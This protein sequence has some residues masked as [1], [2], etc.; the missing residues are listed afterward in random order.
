MAHIFKITT[1]TE[2]LIAEVNGAATASVDFTV[3]NETNKPLRGIAHIQ[4]LEQTQDAWLTLEGEPEKDFPVG[5]KQ[6]FTVKFNK[7][8]QAVEEGKTEPEEKYPYLLSVASAI[9][10]EED[11]DEGPKVTIFKPERKAVTKK[12]VPWWVFLI[13]GIVVL[14]LLVGGIIFG[15]RS[16]P[17]TKETKAVPDVTTKP[18]NIQEAKK[19]L[20]AEGFV[21]QVAQVPAPNRQVNTVLEQVPKGGEEAQAG[22]TVNLTEAEKTTVPTVKGKCIV[23][24]LIAISNAN[25]K[26]GDSQGDKTDIQTCASTVAS[27]APAERSPIAKGSTVNVNFTC[28]SKPTKPCTKIAVGILVEE[29]KVKA[30][31][32][33]RRR[34]DSAVENMMKQKE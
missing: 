17:P 12:G 31:P 29:V 4:A 15:I 24:A 30:N 14:I 2:N 33:D 21:V 34:L 16:C 7:P 1:D 22:S 5:S 3:I 10:P 32:T 20:E 27:T 25:L 11:Y 26:F 6:V 28:V 8:L 18:T 9:R 19:L 13:I 23:D